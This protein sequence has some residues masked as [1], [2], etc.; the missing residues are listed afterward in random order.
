MVI[1][2]TAWQNTTQWNTD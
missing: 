2:R 1:N